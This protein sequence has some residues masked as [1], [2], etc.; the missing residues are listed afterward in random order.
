MTDT[1]AIISINNLKIHL[2][3]M[4]F[5]VVTKSLSLGRWAGYKHLQTK[6]VLTFNVF[7]PEQHERWRPLLD[8]TAT[9]RAE[10]KRVCVDEKVFGLVD[11]GGA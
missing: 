8:W 7:T 9:R 1:P 4:G 3:P 5:T 2:K 6:Q 11:P 10:L